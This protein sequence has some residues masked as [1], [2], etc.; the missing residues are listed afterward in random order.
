MLTP[1]GVTSSAYWNAIKAGNPTHVRM[2]FLGQNIVLDDSDISLTGGLTITDIING[3]VDLVFGKAVAKQITVYIL[4]SSKLDGLIWTSEFTLEMGVDIG[5][6]SVTYWVNIGYFTGERP[7]N[8]TTVNVITFTA[9]DRM[10]KF[11]VLADQF[12]QNISYPITVQNIYNNLCTY[13]GMDKVSG[14][15]LPNIMSRS[16]ASAPVEMTGYTCRDILAWIAEACGCYARINYAGKC[17]MVWF[18]DN[19]S[20]ALT[21]DEEFNVESGDINDGLTWDE[22]DTYKWNEFDNFTWDEVCGYQEMYSIDQIQVKQLGADVN[23]NYPAFYGWNV[24]MI[25]DNPFLSVS[26]ASDITNYIAPLY[27]RMN[28]FGGYM[29]LNIECIGCWLVEAGDVITAD[30]GTNTLSLPVFAR[31]LRWNGSVNDTYEAT[32]NKDRKTY[33]TESDRQQAITAKYIRLFVEDNYYHTQSGIEINAD[34]IEISGSKYLK[35]VSGGTF[36]VQS[37]NFEISS[38]D[39]RMTCGYWKFD[40][41]G[42]TYDNGIDP[43]PFQIARY[44]DAETLSSGIFT[45]YDIGTGMCIIRTGCVE[46]IHTSQS[47]Y[48]LGEY[49]TEVVDDSDTQIVLPKTRWAPSY[50]LTVEGNRTRFYPYVLNGDVGTPNNRILRLYGRFF[51]G[52]RTYTNTVSGV[53]SDD[54]IFSPRSDNLA[55]LRLCVERSSLNTDPYNRLLADFTGQDG[56]SRFDVLLRGIKMIYGST[57]YTNVLN[58]AHSIFIY[59]HREHDFG[60]AFRYESPSASEYNIS[61]SPNLSGTYAGYTYTVKSNGNNLWEM[62]NMK[63]FSGGTGTFTTVNYTNLVQ[64]SSKEIKHNIQSMK[65]VG[66]LIDRLNPV[67]FVYDNDAD[68]KQRM[69]LIYEDTV[70][71]MPEICTENE[72]NK[73]ISYVELIPALLKEIQSL[74]SRVKSLEEREVV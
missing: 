68:E 63:S 17:Q 23:I 29:P 36:D 28:T 66:E 47:G 5:T 71:I 73:A 65:P 41:S 54:M 16:Y 6:P 59:P 15:E 4:N 52:A 69:G 46:N 44:D 3:D 64:S 2:T 20:H 37:A 22:A 31:T 40:N 50:T 35:I 32:G 38:S 34:G 18:T 21:G 45:D 30:V 14:D 1:T 43:L 13:V 62:Y 70:G 33:A 27:N 57:T 53:E 72:A 26:N 11:D 8:I 56:A 10:T 19:T 12:V 55:Y 58:D 25:V 51:Y 7:K 42:S 61:F 9:Y 60:F 24:Y 39:K 67:T 74:R 49:R 48:W